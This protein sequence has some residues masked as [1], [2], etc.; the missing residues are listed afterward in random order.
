MEINFIVEAPPA[1]QRNQKRDTNYLVWPPSLPAPITRYGP[2]H[3][4]QRL[5]LFFFSS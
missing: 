1:L 4:L 2:G 3:F 5:L